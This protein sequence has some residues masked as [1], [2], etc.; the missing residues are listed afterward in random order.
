MADHEDIAPPGAPIR[1]S[2]VPASELVEQLVGKMTRLARKEVEL[3]KTEMKANLRSEAWVAAGLGIAG[4]CALI[5]L[6]LAGVALALFL[7]RWIPP[8]EAALAVAGG[9]LLAGL[10]AGWW[11]WNRRVQSPLEATRRTLRE[12]V[13]WA[14]GRSA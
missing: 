6:N 12:D 7:A 4:L 5:A 13:R 10:T 9:A 2:D 1:P 3:A 14:R 11:G 8:W